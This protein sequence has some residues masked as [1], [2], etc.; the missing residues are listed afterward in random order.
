MREYER[1]EKDYQIS[2]YAELPLCIIVPGINNNRG[3]RTEK[4]LNSIFTQNYTNYRVI[5]TDDA[6]TDGT[7]EVI[8]KYLKFYDIPAEKVVLIKN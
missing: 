4:S 8:E 3:F 2:K 1:V 6:S 7:P 5:L